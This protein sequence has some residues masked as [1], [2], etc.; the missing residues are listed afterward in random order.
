MKKAL[1][2]IGMVACAFALHGMFTID[3]T[4]YSDGDLNG[5]DGW[6]GGVGVYNV[7]TAVGGLNLGGSLGNLSRTFSTAELGAAF[8]PNSSV[9]TYTMNY[10]INAAGGG[11]WPYSVSLGVGNYLDSGS[12]N[13]GFV[14][15]DT[16]WNSVREHVGSPASSTNDYGTLAAASFG[17]ES[18]LSMTID[19]GAGTVTGSRSD[20]GASFSGTFTQQNDFGDTLYLASNGPL[21]VVVHSVSVSAVP[22]PGTYALILGVLAVGFV[23]YRR[24]RK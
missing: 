12:S 22:E 5:Q 1:L 4:S 7:N 14:I 18:T 6:S 9:V 11:S 17:V 13:V 15:F 21:D 19:Y 8:D 2:T 23:A 3:F 10:T 16:G 20:T 24:R